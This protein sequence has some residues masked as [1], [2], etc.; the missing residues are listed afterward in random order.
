V[1]E[2]AE[3]QWQPLGDSAVR[4]QFG[5]TMN[6]E[7]L[8]RIRQFCQ[9]L[10][11]ESIEGI[12]EWVPGYTT[13]VVYFRPWVISYDVLCRLLQASAERAATEV[14]PPPRY[15]VIPVRYGGADGPDLNEMAVYHHLTAAEVVSMHTAPVYLTYLLGFLPGFPYL[16]GLPDSLATPRLATPRARVP[17]G[18]VGI[19]GGQTGVYPFESPGGWRLIGRTSLVLYDS[20]RDPPALLAPGDQVKFVAEEIS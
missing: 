15:V 11:G 7:T 19:G 17:V 10:E 2:P 6:A 1:A 9:A 3:I 12:V 16:G 20:Q 4:A 5:T 14:L 13:V 8:T 18:S